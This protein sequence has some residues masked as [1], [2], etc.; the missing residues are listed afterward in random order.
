[1]PKILIGLL[2]AISGITLLALGWT[3]E[4]GIN[5]LDVHL[6]AGAFLAV[7]GVLF[8]WATTDHLAADRRL[9]SSDK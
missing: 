4:R 5:F 3:T 7:A 9:P 2:S 8:V 1:M 6:Y